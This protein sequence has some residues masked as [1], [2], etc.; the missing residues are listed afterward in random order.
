MAKTAPSQT[1]RREATSGSGVWT[2]SGRMAARCIPILPATSACCQLGGAAADR[3]LALLAI[4]AHGGPRA[5]HHQSLSLGQ[6]DGLKTGSL[7]LTGLRRAH[8]GGDG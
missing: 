7:R 4:T 2:L 6:E 8:P 5:D 3:L 1:R